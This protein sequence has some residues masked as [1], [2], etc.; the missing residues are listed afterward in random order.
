[1]KRPKNRP[2]KFSKESDR[3][4]YFIIAL[5]AFAVYANT[6]LN[7]FVYDDELLVS[8][9]SSITHISNI[10]KF[11]TG[12]AGFNQVFNWFYRPIVSTSYA[13]DYAIWKLNP[14]GFHLTNIIIHVINCLLLY[15]FLIIIFGQKKKT[16]KSSQLRTFILVG[17]VIFAIHPIHTEAVSWV[18]GRTD[19]LAFTFILASFI[20][21]LEY[22]EEEG[23]H[24]N[25]KFTLIC[26]F[27]CISLFAKEVSITL[28]VMIVLY[29]M[30]VKRYNLKTLFKE[31]RYIY[32]LLIL[33]S[34]TYLLLRKSVLDVFP[35]DEKKFYFY[36]KDFITAFLTM[37]QTIPL[38][39]RLLIVPVGLLY[40]YNGYLPY[41]S[42][43]L[44]PEVLICFL[45]IIILAILTVYFYRKNAL[46]SYSIIFF[47]L[48][49]LPVLN[50]A[51][52][53]NLAAERFLYIPSISLI[54]II[55]F[56]GYKFDISIYRSPF[57]AAALIIFLIFTMLTILRNVDWKNNERLYLS[58]DGKPGVALNVNLGN[59]YVQKKQYNKAELYYSRAIQANVNDPL[60]NT[61]LGRAFMLEGKYDSSY[62]YINK[63]YLFDTLTPEPRFTL[64]LMYELSDRTADAINEMEKLQ[65]ISPDYKNS[66]RLLAQLK[67]Q[68]QSDSTNQSDKEHK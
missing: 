13:I 5:V 53:S 52:T 57:N 47:F 55:V 23:A 46:V 49:L 61:N 44:N 21:Y 1:M 24:K 38:Y 10:P 28:P 48:T 33:I 3:T 65:V 15:K 27:Y 14:L 17:T 56:I 60:A 42:S 58:A 36:G 32:L 67:S 25:I 40:Q 22:S 11:F 41:T 51:P 16:E 7:E 62:Y 64:A 20:N 9:D 8:E 35:S 30:I 18:S 29:D 19:L 45:L 63:A 31:R 68:L 12:Q 2:V 4:S 54:L 43:L 26:L 66:K 37:L 50:I 34:L 59:L 6:L 39:I